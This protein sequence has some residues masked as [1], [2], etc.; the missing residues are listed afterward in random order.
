MSQGLKIGKGFRGKRRT[1]KPK[2]QKEKEIEKENETKI[3]EYSIQKKDLPFYSTKIALDSVHPL[4]NRFRLPEGEYIIERELY[5][6]NKAPFRPRLKTALEFPTNE[7]ET[8]LGINQVLIDDN[9]KKV[10][11][12]FKPYSNIYF[13]Y[14]NNFLKFDYESGSITPKKIYN[15]KIPI[16]HFQ[17]KEQI[18]HKNI[19]FAVLLKNNNIYVIDQTENKIYNIN[20]DNK[21][22]KT[23]FTM[24]QFLPNENLEIAAS[25]IKGR[26]WI[27]SSDRKDPKR[28]DLNFKNENE[29]H[30]I[31][32][33]DKKTN[34][35]GV[36]NCGK[37][38][39]KSFEFSH[40]GDKIATVDKA[41]YFNIFN[42][43][44]ISIHLCFKSLFGGFT[45]LSWSNDDKY[46]L[47]GGED[48]IVCLWD[49]QNKCIIARCLGHQNWVKSVKFDPYYRHTGIFLNKKEKESNIL[50]IKLNKKINETKK[51]SKQKIKN[52]EINSDQKLEIKP[53][54]LKEDKIPN[55]QLEESINEKKN[56]EG[57]RRNRGNGSNHNE[58]NQKRGQ[59]KEIMQK[60]ENSNN[61]GNEINTN[62]VKR[63]SSNVKENGSKSNIENRGNNGNGSAKNQRRNFIRFGSVGEDGLLC[64][65][66]AEKNPK[67]QN[68]DNNKNK[69]KKKAHNK[70]LYRF[71][72]IPEFEKK[73]IN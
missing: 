43:D 64:I 20:I 1:D 61:N 10:K 5:V 44:R 54:S 59:G 19:I 49:V 17:I 46:I 38:H 56:G 3:L 65:F 6:E 14:K 18:Q 57:G 7:S 34:P 4:K 22:T 40:Q 27:F 30:F 71:Q 60:E 70:K 39:I 25:D 50:N 21:I 15:I 2:N 72:E 53:K 31:Y 11:K 35:I 58:S 26:I 41:G 36:F 47:T 48:D 8:Y 23:P 67:N 62:E 52:D 12:Q 69:I 13:N 63:K 9:K 29:F 37:Y 42:I 51:E 73:M 66:E 45:C 24:V 68:L 32:N 16:L 55:E 33:K 28:F